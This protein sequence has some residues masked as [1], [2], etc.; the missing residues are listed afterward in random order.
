MDIKKAID[1][2][3][4]RLDAI[5]SI[6]EDKTK[7]ENIGRDI[8]LDLRTREDEYKN[9]MFP[10]NLTFSDTM[11]WIWGLIKYNQEAM[12]IVQ[13]FQQEILE[14]LKKYT[15]SCYYSCQGHHA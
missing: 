13:K 15:A 10:L 2:E 9:L 5:I 3:A 12:P 7:T 11:N 6:S 14:P 4:D 1:L 8:I